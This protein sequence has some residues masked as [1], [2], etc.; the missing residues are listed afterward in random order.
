MSKIVSIANVSFKYDSTQ[1]KPLDDISLTIEK[2]SVFG[3][4]G[5]NGAGKTTL[6]QILFGNLKPDTGTVEICGYRH[7]NLPRHVLSF[8]TERPY[9]HTHFRFKEYL[10]YLD[11]I[12]TT[13]KGM[14]MIN[15]LIDFVHLNDF[16]NDQLKNFSKGMLQRVGIAQALLNKPEILILD[17]PMSG[18]DIVGQDLMREVIQKV[19]AQGTTV[20]ISSHNL[21]EIERLCDE[22]GFLHRGKLR[23]ITPEEL[24]AQQ[25]YCLILDLPEGR[26][27]AVQNTLLEA[28]PGLRLEDGVIRFSMENTVTYFAVLDHLQEQKVR[29]KV[30]EPA[31]LSLETLIMDYLTEEE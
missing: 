3:L 20:I 14:E 21:Y 7:D 10:F 30:L 24:A 11:Q 31:R 9:F 6:L 15:H 19:N 5:K 8:L 16:A 22:V 2:G 27:M 18:L 17:E 25:E 12:S 23:L 28:V 26:R 13:P 4:V 1:V 29:I